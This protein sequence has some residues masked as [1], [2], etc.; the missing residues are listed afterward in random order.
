MTTVAL[1]R[2]DTVVA[3]LGDI[4][5]LSVKPKN[6]GGR[7]FRDARFRLTDVYSNGMAWVF[8][9]LVCVDGHWLPDPTRRVRDYRVALDE[10][11]AA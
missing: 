1:I 6:L 5:R 4:V 2:D 7:S 8:G 10:I 9:P 11:E 3:R